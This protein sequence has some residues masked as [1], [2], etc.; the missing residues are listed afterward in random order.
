MNESVGSSRATLV[1]F[2]STFFLFPS[3]SLTG[4]TCTMKMWLCWLITGG[5][6]H[7]KNSRLLTSAGFVESRV[8]WHGALV[9][10]G[11]DQREIMGWVAIKVTV[12]GFWWRLCLLE[13][14]RCCAWGLGI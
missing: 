13:G 6:S 9:L 8:S 10:K 3:V 7:R 2:S 1:H 5:G 12:S 14:L 11:N 4:S